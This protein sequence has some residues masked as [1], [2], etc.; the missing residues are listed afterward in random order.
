MREN[1]TDGNSER[2]IYAN[3]I[4]EL[5][6]SKNMIPQE[7]SDITRIDPANLSRI[8]KN[9]KQGLSL[10]NAHRIAAALNET[11]EDVFVFE[12]PAPNRK[13]NEEGD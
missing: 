3:R 13:F 9:K 2:K 11:I 7:L 8:I 1:I 5:L 6:R 10:W 12:R 4:K